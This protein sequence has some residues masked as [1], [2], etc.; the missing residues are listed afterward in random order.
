MHRPEP[1]YP[2][3]ID[4]HGELLLDVFTH[5]SLRQDGG[6][7]DNE[8]YAVLGEKVFEASVTNSIFSSYPHLVGKDIEVCGLVGTSIIS[9]I[10]CHY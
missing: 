4:L 3:P 2:P 7:G 9:A 1:R 6:S 5:R 8:R 10:D